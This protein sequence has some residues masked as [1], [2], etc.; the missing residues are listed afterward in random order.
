MLTIDNTQ[1]SCFMRCQAEWYEQYVLKHKAQQL[2][3]RDDAAA[4]GIAIHNVLENGYKNGK[5][6]LTVD[7][8]DEL[9]LTNEALM[10][11]RIM[12]EAYRNKYPGG[13]VEFPWT[14]LEA[15]ISFII[16][17]VYQIKAKVDGYFE[18]VDPIIV[19]GGVSD[20]YLQPGIYSFETKSKSSGY[21][22]G[23]YLADWAANMQASF[24][25]LTLKANAATLGID[26]AMVKGILVNVID[27]P[28]IYEPR[29]TCK[30]C[31]V[32]TQVKYFR[33]CGKVYHCPHCDFGNTFTGPM[34][35]ARVDPP[36]LYR[37]LVERSDERLAFDLQT[38]KAVAKEMEKVA[39]T[40]NPI[41]T[42]T[43]CV[44][45]QWR[46]RCQ[47]YE[48]HNAI[49]PMSAVGYP[50]FVEFNP[51]AYLTRKID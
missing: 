43:Q 36:F 25:L 13:P 6:N 42:R 3:E 24:Q 5:F 10:E 17:D 26:P 7:T 34:G 38:I 39:T 44:N 15:P 1:Y 46:K 30:G 29:R 37:F 2:G 45:M 33:L 18:C 20:I 9:T 19:S 50:G 21:D 11:V 48:P 28:K 31:D 16:D 49:V 14:G 32:M 27:R 23:L 12:A 40:H 4:I 41:Y 51:T 35:Q 8:A 47:F 22:R